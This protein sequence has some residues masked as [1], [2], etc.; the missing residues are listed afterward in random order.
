MKK[1]FAL[2]VAL[3][4]LSIPLK[5]QTSDLSAIGFSDATTVYAGGANG[6]IQ[7]STDAGATWTTQTSGT[8]NY[9]LGF[10]SS[11]ALVGW[12]VG[13]NPINGG[14]TILKTTDGGLHWV[15]Q[16]SPLFQPLTGISMVSA[17]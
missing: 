13:G 9:L 12:F 3:I 2:I 10:A 16:S 4:L 15:A 7:H 6:F 5:A 14:A 1:C 17:T 8:T 11:S